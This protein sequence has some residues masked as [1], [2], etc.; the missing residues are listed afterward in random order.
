MNRPARSG[1]TLIESLV[2][3]VLLSAFLAVGCALVQLLLATEQQDRDRLAL[4]ESTA[5]LG[6]YFRADVHDALDATLYPPGRD[7]PAV[8]D[9][10]MPDGRL[11]R[12]LAGPRAVSRLVTFDGLPLEADDF[13]LGRRVARF[14]VDR[15]DGVTLVGLRYDRRKAARAE[16]PRPVHLEAALGL[17]RR[18]R[19]ALAEDPR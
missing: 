13:D 19:P 4:R 14:S 12:Y 1:F 9:L 18:F 5:R 11:V 2:T 3:M 6:R 16:D 10:D 15:A 8:L 17:D 7:V